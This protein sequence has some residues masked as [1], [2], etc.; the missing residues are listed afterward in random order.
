MTCK[1]GIPV[2]LVRAAGLTRVPRVALNCAL[3]GSRRE[4]AITSHTVAC[5]ECDLLISLPRLGARQRSRCPRCGHVLGFGNLERARHAL[6]YALTGAALLPLSLLFPFMS[7]ARGGVENEMNLFQSAQTLYQDGSIVLSFLV[8]GFIV[9]LP[10]LVIL[11]VLL[12]SLSLN[13]R[14]DLPGLPWVARFLYR[15]ESWGMVEVFIIGV[16][17]SLVKIA[18]MATVG[19]GLSLWTYVAFAAVLVAAV[20]RLDK[21]VVWEHIESVRR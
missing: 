2:V 10:S 7:F 19:L 13:T 5:S 6:P 11:A 20:T 15:V 21:L 9:V 14:R 3:G 16:F 18:K 4:R 8:F 12:I 17:V 1:Q